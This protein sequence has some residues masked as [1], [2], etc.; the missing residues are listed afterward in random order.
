MA[1]VLAALVVGGGLHLVVSQPRPEDVPV[2]VAARALPVGAPL[3]EGDTEL[4][5]LPASAL[6]EGA[7]EGLPPGRHQVA[8]PLQAGEILSAAD[9]RTSALLEGLPDRVAVFVPLGEPTVAEALGAGDAVDV[10]SPVDGAVVAREAL[11]LQTR[12]GEAPGLWLAVEENTAAGL[13]AARGADPVGAALSVALRP[14][15]P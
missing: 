14:P 9:L 1:A 4:R 5:H 2:V 15:P 13:A 11:V 8:V 12:G 10:H 3:G 7:L 6:P